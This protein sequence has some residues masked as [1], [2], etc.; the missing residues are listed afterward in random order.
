MV[1]GE[2]G[3]VD[4]A[5]RA[6]DG[7]DIAVLVHDVTLADGDG[8]GALHFHAFEDVEVDFL[9]V[10]FRRYGTGLF[11]VPHDNIRIRADRNAA[12][13]RV[14]VED[15]RGVGGGDGHEF[16]HGQFAAVHAVVPEDAHA[17][18]DAAG[19]VGDF[20]EVVAP[21][22]LLR[23]AE[24][25]MVR[26]GRVQRAGLQTFPQRLLVF[27]AAK[28]R[29]HDMGGGV[30]EIRAFVDAVVNQQMPCEHFAKHALAVGAGALNGVERLDGG[31]VHDIERHVQNIGNSNRAFGR[32]AFHAGRARHRVA[33][34]AGYP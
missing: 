1:A 22:G 21:R 30:F 24:A 17:V 7:A 32:F 29:R 2:G 34:G 14:D 8:I 26:R 13:A 25:A 19:A 33:F 12:L 3:A 4:V 15:F 10:G 6:F 27:F 5:A 31:V 11:R 9:V 20:A 23:R 18:F 28:R 16:I